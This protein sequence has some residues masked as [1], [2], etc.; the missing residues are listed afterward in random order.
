MHPV[1]TF[2]RVTII[3]G[4]MIAAASSPSIGQTAEGDAFIATPG[5]GT[6]SASEMIG[7]TVHDGEGTS[8]GSVVD[9]LVGGPEQDGYVVFETGGFLG[10]GK[11]QIAA[12]LR[13]FRVVAERG[14]EVEPPGGT[15]TGTRLP[16]ENSQGVP[17]LT[18]GAAAAGLNPLFLELAVSEEELAAAPPYSADPRRIPAIA[19]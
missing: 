9:V 18:G 17:D 2:Q 5:A 8:L 15:V 11:K 1:V 14:E 6:W 4:L 13:A 19:P 16:A 3:A 7:L 12:P 10:S